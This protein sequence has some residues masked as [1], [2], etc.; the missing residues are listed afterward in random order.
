[1]NK[2]ETGSPATVPGTGQFSYRTFGPIETRELFEPL[3]KNQKE[4]NDRR[5]LGGVRVQLDAWVFFNP[6][7]GVQGI[8]LYEG[9]QLLSVNVSHVG[10]QKRGKWGRY[11]QSH[12]AYTIPERR[13]QGHAKTLFRYAEAR[14]IQQGAHRLKDLIGAWL[15][16]YLH[17]SLGHTIWG[18]ERRGHLVIDH[19]LVHAYALDG[20]PSNVSRQIPS[21]VGP[22]TYEDGAKLFGLNGKG[23][24]AGR[25]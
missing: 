8:G 20:I 9:D 21:C 19:P 6:V 3:W 5:F 10:K 16:V 18:L 14:W 22:I 24:D 11:V 4:P 15:G 13:R 2:T 25:P 7:D 12:Y 17:R 23:K 1:M